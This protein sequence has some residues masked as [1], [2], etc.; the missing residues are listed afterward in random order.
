ME[1]FFDPIKNI[2]SKYDGDD[3]FVVGKGRSADDAL[4]EA[5]SNGIVINLNDSERIIHGDICVFHAP[6]V[7]E[8]LNEYGFHDSLYITPLELPDNVLTVR[9]DYIPFDQ[10]NAQLMFS[11]F[12]EKRLVVEGALLVSALRIAKVIADYKM[13]RQ[14]VYFVGFDF[15]IGRGYSSK[16][17][18]DFSNGETNYQSSIISAQEHYFIM[19][20]YLLRESNLLISHVGNKSYSKLGYNEFNDKFCEPE[21]GVFHD[22]KSAVS[23]SGNIGV[24][25]GT[26]GK[27][28][29]TAEITT[30][31]FGDLQ[32]L[33]IMIRKAKSA[34]ADLIKLQK[35]DVETFYTEE[36]LD[37][38]Y[39]SP[40]GSTFRSYRNAIEL[41]E[42]GFEF[43]DRVCREVEI[44]WFVSVLDIPSFEFM[45][46]FERDFVKLPSTISQ[47]RDFIKMVAQSYHKA[48]VVSTGYTDQ[49]YEDFLI[50]TFKNSSD[51]YILQCTSAYPAPPEDCNIAVVRHYSHLAKRYKNI[52]P[53]YSS[54]DAGSRASMLAVAAGA[55]MVEKHVK[56]DDT[57]WAH[58]DTVALDLN[59]SEF[60]DFIKDIRLAERFTGNET[61]KLIDIEH[62]KYWKH[63]F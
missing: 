63:S 23:A 36:Q 14:H 60:D 46:Q 32:R 4:P 39:D 2:A 54:H 34:G 16:I 56:Y 12:N 44:D 37:S 58:F 26:T 33:E 43:V 13:H 61:K 38:P 48:V 8:S 5:F 25:N 21:T 55:C 41:D 19:F 52:R 24:T 11:R 57:E 17:K 20:S 29:V 47:H 6:W 28:L 3:I 22:Q 7:I 27:V 9:A 40:F 45:Q 35:R 62:H 59:G 18:Y 50:E 30:N 49:S 53:G 1:N 15:N 51:L 42:S 31:H 10:E